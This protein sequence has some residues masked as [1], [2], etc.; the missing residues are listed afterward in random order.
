MCGVVF[1]PTPSA[2][3][4]AVESGME[5]Y[6]TLAKNAFTIAQRSFSQVQYFSR[7]GKIYQDLT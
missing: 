2:L 6:Q 4:D 5:Q 1:D 7:L 3:V